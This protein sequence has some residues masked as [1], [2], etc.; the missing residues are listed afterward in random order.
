MPIDARHLGLIR[1]YLPA[2]LWSYALGRC[3]REIGHHVTP[4]RRCR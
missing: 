4:H 3:H 1:P 2:L